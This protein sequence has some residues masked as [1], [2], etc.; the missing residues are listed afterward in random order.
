MAFT[1][2]GTLNALATST[3]SGVNANASASR[4]AL[5]GYAYP[6]S[7]ITPVQGWG[8][9]GSGVYGTT[10]A[11]SSGAVYGSHTGT[12]G[13]GVYGVA[14]G[15]SGIGVYGV[16][17]S[18]DGAGVVGDTQS[19]SGAAGRAYGTNGSGV[20]GVI[21]N[22]TAGFGV[23]GSAAAPA[24]A[25]CYAG[26]FNGKVYVGGALTKA[27]GGFLIDHPLDP[28]NKTLEH[29]FVESPERKNIYDGVG[30]ADASGELTIQ[31]PA[32]FETLNTE[33]RYQLT[34]LG[35]AASLYVKQE[36][37]RGQFIIAGAQPGQ[38]VSWLVTGTRMDAWALANKMSVEADKAPEERGTY[39][40]T[41]SFGLSRE[42][43]VEMVRN[44]TLATMIAS[45]G[46]ST[47]S[48]P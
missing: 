17:N 38:R 27:G 10:P 32:Y 36:I 20:A 28:E 31:L 4:P 25:G 43:A 12:S 22:T 16:G 21:F 35:N 40:S 26:Y 39:L 11:S 13:Y 45:A 1:Y 41:E 24:V 47:K 34:A 30:I 33:Y 46:T 42:K 23:Y 44:P 19:G 14:N 29:S 5:I 7:N 2:N 8:S 37:Q 18:A 3:E 9:A 6:G 48:Q 15:S